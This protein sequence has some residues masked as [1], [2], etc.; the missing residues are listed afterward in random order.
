MAVDLQ[1]EEF[2]TNI[3]I[4]FERG[5]N[6]IE[7]EASQSFEDYLFRIRADLDALNQA[8]AL[9]EI[10]GIRAGNPALASLLSALA[11]A[12]L[13]TDSTTEGKSDAYTVQNVNTD[14]AY[15][16]DSTSVSELADVLGTL[17]ADLQ[18]AGILGS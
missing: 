10:T 1:T 13:I 16:A 15:D 8:L 18:T 7:V 17:I 14:R 6:G 11:S 5:L 12:G 9:G 3:P 2:D 4:G